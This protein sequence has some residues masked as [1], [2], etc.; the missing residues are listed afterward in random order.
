MTQRETA[1]WH[2][3][4]NL[5]ASVVIPTYN[6][7]ASL[8]RVL[9]GLARQTV[10]PEQFEVVL[11]ADG[12][13]DGTAPLSRA[14]AALLPYTLRV[15]EQEN[16]GPAAARN[17]GV[18]ETRAALVIFVDDDVLPAED[19]LA[20]H[21]AAHGPEA[22]D[23]VVALGPLLPPLDVRLNAWGAWE[24]RALLRQ[25]ADME[26]GRWQPTYR[27]F[28]TGNASLYKRHILE[29]GG[30]H[31]E[32]LRAEDI[33]LGLRLM[34]QGCTFAF[35]PEARAWHYVH[36]S[37]ASWARMPDAYGRA[38]VEMARIHGPWELVNIA[39]EFH[40]RNRLTRL[41]TRACAGSRRAITVLAQVLR[42]IAITAWILHADSISLASCSL[43]FNLLN[44]QAIAEALGGKEHFWRIFDDG[45]AAQTDSGVYARLVT[46]TAE[47]VQASSV[48]P[49]PQQ[50]AGVRI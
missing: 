4:G 46:L 24:E 45:K 29:A 17:R 33:E 23:R 21:L 5:R 19:F 43:L 26:A 10:S 41:L 2:D 8:E 6:R 30:F 50:P 39:C 14:L 48:G 34:A 40:W 25:Y 22:E 1:S 11:V 13:T 47:T 27:Q 36:R 35:L 44:Y 7:Y 9:R 37:F 32:F 28:Y 38:S 49:L 16:A 12:C 3:A 31:P 20:V 18:A 15:I 42:G